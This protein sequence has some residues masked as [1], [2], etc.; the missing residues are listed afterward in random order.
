MLV[1]SLRLSSTGRAYGLL[2]TPQLVTRPPAAR[3]CTCPHLAPSQLVLGDGVFQHP[4]PE[5]VLVSSLP[6]FYLL[7]TLS[8]H[9][10]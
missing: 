9:K 2:G 6:S 7:Y 5:Q 8:L 3:R 10:L 4:A 1:C